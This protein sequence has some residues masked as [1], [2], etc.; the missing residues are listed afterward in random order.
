MKEIRSE[1][2][3]ISGT[4]KNQGTPGPAWGWFRCTVIM[5][6]P[7]HRLTGQKSIN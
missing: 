5:S 1:M 6:H 3:E 2:K 7:S 4:V